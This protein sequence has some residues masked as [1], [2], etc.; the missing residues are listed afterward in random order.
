MFFLVSE[1][2]A[3]VFISIQYIDL[4]HE[5]IFIISSIYLEKLP[6]LDYKLIAV[7]MNI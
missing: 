5:K 1:L 2:K 3:I 4:C 7:K 6:I